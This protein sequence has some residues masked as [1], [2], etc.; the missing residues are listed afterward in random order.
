LVWINPVTGE[1]AFQVHGLAARK[2]FLRS[3]VDESPTVIDDVVA[4]RSFL[5]SI[6][7]RILRPEYI[8]LPEVEEGDIV[9]WDNY[10]TFH[11]AVDY[12]VEKYGPRTMHQANIGASKGPVGPVPIPAVG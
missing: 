6:Q 12:P 3:S 7:T 4:I 9:M 10:G 5:H 8:W 1:K 11:T 2:I